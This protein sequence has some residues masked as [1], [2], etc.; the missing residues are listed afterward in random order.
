M[1]LRDI[2]TQHAHERQIGV[3]VK[4]MQSATDGLLRDIDIV[5]QRVSCKGIKG[6][7]APLTTGMLGGE[8]SRENNTLSYTL[9][10]DEVPVDEINYNTVLANTR[11]A[12][13]DW[14]F[15][16]CKYAA[17]DEIE[18]RYLP[19]AR[20]RIAEEMMKRHGNAL[21]GH[22]AYRALHQA[23]AEPSI[24]MRVELVVA[25]T[26]SEH[27]RSRFKDI[28]DYYT[29]IGGKVV[30]TP[31]LQVR[32]YLDQPYRASSDAALGARQQPARRAPGRE[33]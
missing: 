4:K 23:C 21:R 17:N 1:S 24:D 8:W 26:D 31:R 25:A 15:A 22:D 11:A 7:F 20:L 2:Y 12:H 6:L 16:E 9:V 5:N 32:V 27:L 10:R 18:K 14:M 13:R 30:A 3:L 29:D 33:G 19:N 28:R